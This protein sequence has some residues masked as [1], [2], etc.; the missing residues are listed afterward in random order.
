M[1][2][3]GAP[4]REARLFA[5]MLHGRGRSAQEMLALGSAFDVAGVHYLCPQAPDAS[6]YPESFLEPRARNQPALRASLSA[7]SAHLDALNAAGVPDERI[8]LCGFSQGACMV[9]ETLIR[10]PAAYAAALIFTG[11]LMGPPG[12]PWSTSG[13]LPPVPV[14]LTGSEIDEWVPAWRTRETA[15][16]LEALG[17]A[18]ELAIY[19]SREHMVSDDEIVRA[20]RLLRGSNGNA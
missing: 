11:G 8:V 17:A 15:L 7:I 4:W 6:W 14:L 13:R 3:G 1:L 16:T 20:R 18:V 12:T 9:A 19:A 10:R 2:E 5:L